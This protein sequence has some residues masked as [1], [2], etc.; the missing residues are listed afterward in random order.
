MAGSADELTELREH[1]AE[2][3]ALY[4]LGAEDADTTEQSSSDRVGE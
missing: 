4:N 3:P 2:Q 1:A